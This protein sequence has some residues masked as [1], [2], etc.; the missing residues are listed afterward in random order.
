MSKR[1]YQEKV[2]WDDMSHGEAKHHIRKKLSQ[3]VVKS[4][5]DYKRKPK[6]NTWEDYLDG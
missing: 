4:K 2:D 6:S 1:R 3:K 5:K